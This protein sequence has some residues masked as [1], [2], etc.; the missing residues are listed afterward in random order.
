MDIAFDEFLMDAVEQVLQSEMTKGIW[1]AIHHN[2]SVCLLYLSN[3]DEFA[4]AYA[5]S[6][7][8]EG[9]QRLAFDLHTTVFLV[10]KKCT[11]ADRL[12]D[13]YRSA[14]EQ[15]VI[16]AGKPEPNGWL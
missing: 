13:I 9:L 7:Y 1:T 12:L 5:P 11:V 2:M 6:K 3:L 8:W 10:D 15:R 14:M 16:F 4:V